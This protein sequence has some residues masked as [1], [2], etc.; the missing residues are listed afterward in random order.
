MPGHRSARLQ[1]F[2][3]ANPTPRPRAVATRAPAPAPAPADG[4][5]ER[6]PP[7]GEAE[8]AADAEA[9]AVIQ[10]AKGI[11]SNGSASRA[12]ASLRRRPAAAAAAA[13]SAQ[14]A[15]PTTVE[16]VKDAG[17]FG[18]EYTVAAD[19]TLVVVS[20]AG[21]DAAPAPGAEIL[22]VGGVDVKAD[23][24]ALR[25]A[26]DSVRSTVMDG[27]MV[28]WV[29]APRTDA[30][31]GD[32]EDVRL[33]ESMAAHLA[34]PRPQA[35]SGAKPPAGGAEATVFRGRTEL[36]REWKHNA[37]WDIESGLWASPFFGAFTAI[38]FFSLVLLAQLV[39][40]RPGGRARTCSVNAFRVCLRSCWSSAA[41]SQKTALPS[42]A[43]L[44]SVWL[45]R[46]CPR[47]S[48]G[49]APR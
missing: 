21:G 29:F 3:R 17:G 49:K 7:E 25:K 31:A 6:A 9:A 14:P 13:A 11:L 16:L 18:V 2:K 8:A 12:S 39:R 4:P 23:A 30:A 45:L 36:R 32:S 43:G 46:P 34:R 24:D 26:L 38:R 10:Q 19:G 20:C 44:C 28:A 40:P 37:V 48:P 42:L 41:F 15:G 5:P 22:A 47:G 27:E 33:A 1:Q 35:D